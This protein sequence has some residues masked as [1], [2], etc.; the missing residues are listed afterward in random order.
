MDLIGLPPSNQERID[1]LNDAT[2]AAFD[3]VVDDLLSRPEFGERWGR[4]WLDLARYADTNGYEKDRPRS[5]WPYRDWVLQSIN[6]DLPFDEFSIC[7][8][9]GDM[10]PNGDES[11]RIA[12]GFHRNTMLNEEGGIDPLEFRFY[13]MN[14]RIATTGMVWMGL[15]IGCAQCHSHKFDP[16]SHRDYYEFMALMNNSDEPDMEIDHAGTRE[17]RAKVLAKIDALEQSLPEKF[18]LPSKEDA[19]D[20]SKSNG[21][22]VANGSKESHLAAFQNALDT[23]YEESRKAYVPWSPWCPSLGPPTFPSWS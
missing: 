3:R 8:L 1:F 7:Q 16:I 12:T 20:S 6:R 18:P 2:E 15:T 14:D 4:T 19:E 5:I 11:T 13:A 17:E 23:W 10:L 21:E 22:R 9:A